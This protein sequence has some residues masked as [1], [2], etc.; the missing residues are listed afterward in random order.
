ML[1]THQGD[2][3]FEKDVFAMAEI[4]SSYFL[5][6]VRKVKAETREAEIRKI[7]NTENQRNNKKQ[8][9]DEKAAQIHLQQINYK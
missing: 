9:K 2:V 8:D 6:P 3:K 4:D 1:K 7:A 5:G